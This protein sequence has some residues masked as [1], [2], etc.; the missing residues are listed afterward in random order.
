MNPVNNGFVSSLIEKIKS[1]TLYLLMAAVL[2][3][4]GFAVYFWNESV[5]LKE[6]PQKVAQDET[7]KLINSVS[8]LII[9]PEGET[10]TIA[11]VTDP[12]RLK[13]Q[14]FFA[15]AQTGDKVLIY[16]NARKA[17]LYSLIQHKIV[18]VAP[19]NIGNPQTAPAQ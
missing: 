9:L 5:A 13:D 17:I 4:A 18:E 3:A 11:T 15:K 19:I 7:R 16:T 6:N 2:V 14:P 8:K 12:E 1:L 10:P